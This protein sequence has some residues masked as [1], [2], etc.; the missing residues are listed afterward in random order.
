VEAAP[1]QGG[2]LQDAERIVIASY[3]V[4]RCVGGDGVR[5]PDRIAA[6]VSELGADIVGLQEIDRVDGVDQLAH[7]A[8]ATGFAWLRGPT[9]ASLYGNGLLTRLSI[10]N[11]ALIDLSLA[12]REPRGAI[13]AEIDWRGRRLRVVVTH[14][15]LQP[16]E[17]MVQCADLLGRLPQMDADV[18]VL[19]GDFNEWW[20]LSPLLS[21]LRGFFGNARSARSFPAIAPLLALDRVWVKPAGVLVELHAHRSSLARRASDHLPIRAVLDLS[22]ATGAGKGAS[23]VESTVP[24]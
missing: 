23:H 16:E 20:A 10:R 9:S 3:N 12:G 18:S 11:A 5:D 6:V 4:H 7:V 15:G 1:A 13:D 2:G 22:R 19:L 17:R 8:L 14:L 24:E 21:R